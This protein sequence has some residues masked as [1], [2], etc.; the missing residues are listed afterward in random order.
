MINVFNIFFTNKFTKNHISFFVIF[1][2]SCYSFG[3]Q[4][5]LHNQYVYNPIVINPAFSGVSAIS[6]ISLTNRSQW[7]GFS[8]GITTLSLSGNYALNETHGVG[9]VLFQDNTG[10]IRITGLE[11]DY[12]FKFPLLLD[13]TMSLGLG[14]L[15]YQY[16]YD[17]NQVNPNTPGSINDPYDPVLDVSDK[18]IGVD[19]NFGMF[20]YSDFIFAGVS[21]LNMIQSSTIPSFDDNAPNQLVRHY[22]ALAGYHYFNDA[23]KIG[24]EQTV[25]MRSTAY[26]GVQ[27]DFNIKTDFND[28]FYL[29]C[30]YRTNQE[31]LAGF[32]IKYGKFGFVYN[33]D[34]NYGEIGDYSNSSH[35]IGL[36][37]YLHNARNFFSWNRDLNLQYK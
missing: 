22:Y 24:I 8:D 35:E 7:V 16:L 17:A 33:I 25:L 21:V 28:S 34:I 31:I 13:Y 23:S 18:V 9:G 11:L 3:Q 6:H 1:C 15:P 4:L 10:A 29:L 12:S 32:G 20:I 36:I 2:I 14:L 19:M 26:S 30:G 5:P 37:Y 27:F